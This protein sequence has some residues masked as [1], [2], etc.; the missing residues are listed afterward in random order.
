[1][2]KVVVVVV[3][4]TTI[5]VE[6][7]VPRVVLVVLVIQPIPWLHLRELI[8]IRTDMAEMEHADKCV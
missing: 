4:H 5:E 7:A 3:G 1:M 8:L 2:L 6:W